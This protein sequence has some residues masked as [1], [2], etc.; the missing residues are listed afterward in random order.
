MM[1][2]DNDKGETKKEDKFDAYVHTGDDYYRM[3]VTR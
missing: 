1:V 2:D 3:M